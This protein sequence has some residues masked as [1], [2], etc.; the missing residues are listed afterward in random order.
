MTDVPLALPPNVEALVSAFLRDQVEISDIVD[1]RVYT[2]V[3]SNATYPLM[4]VTVLDSIPHT[5]PSWGGAYF[6]QIEAF[7]G[8]KGE[9]WRAAATAIATMSARIVGTHPE[10]VVNGVTSSGIRDVPDEDHEP[11]KPRF[12]FTATLYARPVANVSAS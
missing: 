4:R 2:A 9:A 7:G 6:V 12:L 10:G 1:D 5:G 8:S 11:N 3:P